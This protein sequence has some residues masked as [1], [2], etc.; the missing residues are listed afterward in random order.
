MVFEVWEAEGEG[1]SWREARCGRLGAK[2]PVDL[3]PGWEVLGGGG[4]IWR[5]LS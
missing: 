5:S 3:A 4:G 1:V 2:L